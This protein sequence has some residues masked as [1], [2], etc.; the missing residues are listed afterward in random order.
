M[1]KMIN[2]EEIHDIVGTLDDALVAAI[3]AT[4]ATIKDVSEAHA[5]LT[6]DDSLGKELRHPCQ[7]RAAMVCDLLA[8]EIEPPEQPARRPNA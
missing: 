2:A 6:A 4:G 3:I 5:W 7:G 8:S 1:E